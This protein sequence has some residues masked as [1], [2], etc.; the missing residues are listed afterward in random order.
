M[1]IVKPGKSICWLFWKPKRAAELC[2]ANTTRLIKSLS[3]KASKIATLQ[4][5]MRHDP[6]KFMAEHDFDDLMSAS[7]H[8]LVWE[9]KRIVK[10]LTVI[11]NRTNSLLIVQH[12]E[13]LA[14]FKRIVNKL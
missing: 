1:K 12:N 3:R 7:D 14:E 11:N 10:G 13:A 5:K 6:I 9:L 8:V 2:I 4:Q